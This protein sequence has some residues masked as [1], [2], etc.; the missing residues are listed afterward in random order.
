MQTLAW[1]AAATIFLTS[2]GL[3][4][5]RNWRISIILL[6]VQYL[7]MFLLLLLRL[8]VGLATVKVVAG[9][10]S[11]AILGM[12][13]SGLTGKSVDEEG[14]WPRGRL[15]RLFMAGAVGILVAGATPSVESLMAN[16]GYAVTSGGLMLIAMGLL[17]LGISSQVLRVTLG[18]MTVLTGFEILYATVE[19]SALVTGLLAVIT[20]GLALVGSYLMIASASSSAEAS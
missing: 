13:R 11:S 4:I 8:P 10:M 5:S 6:S 7:A 15:F 1:I 12:T 17:H 20:L 9:W 18:L 3:L 19:G 16:A 14:I 2:V